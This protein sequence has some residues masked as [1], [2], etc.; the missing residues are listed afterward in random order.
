MILSLFRLIVAWFSLDEGNLVKVEEQIHEEEMAKATSPRV[1]GHEAPVATPAPIPVPV[2]VDPAMT[3]AV[4]RSREMA[5]TPWG[6]SAALVEGGAGGRLRVGE[7]TVFVERRMVRSDDNGWVSLIVA[8]SDSDADLT[9]GSGTRGISLIP[10]DLHR[11]I[12]G[13]GAFDLDTRRVLR[14]NRP[15][16]V[17]VPRK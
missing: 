8:R 6:G 9:Y 3:S 5:A 17:P 15:T 13:A 7:R 10:E 2:Q 11:Q 12:L 4:Q 14:V 1:S 16:R